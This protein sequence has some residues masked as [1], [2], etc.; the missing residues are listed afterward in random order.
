[1]AH[2]AVVRVRIEPRSDAEHRRAVLQDL[3][4]PGVRALPGF[5]RGTWLNDDQGTGTCVL[6]FDHEDG[7]RAGLELLTREGGPPVLDASLCAVE[8]ETER[9]S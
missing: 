3:V 1:M 6:V 2:A 5:V 7:A 4:V 9:A 8:L